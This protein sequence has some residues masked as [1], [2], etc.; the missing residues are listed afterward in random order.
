MIICRTEIKKNI[1]LDTEQVSHDSG[2]NE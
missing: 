1:C 2:I